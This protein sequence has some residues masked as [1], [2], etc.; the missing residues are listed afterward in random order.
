MKCEASE[1]NKLKAILKSVQSEVQLAKSASN[2]LPKKRKLDSSSSGSESSSMKS[3]SN[4]TPKEAN[5][6]QDFWVVSIVYHQIKRDGLK[7]LHGILMVNEYLLSIL[8]M[9]VIPKYHLLTLHR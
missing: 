5:P 7:T 8:L 4:S 6:K 9:V 1:L 3:E 2:H